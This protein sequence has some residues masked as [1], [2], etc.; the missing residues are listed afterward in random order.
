[1]GSDGKGDLGSEHM[2]LAGIRGCRLGLEKGISNPFAPE[3]CLPST[4]GIWWQGSHSWRGKSRRLGA[5]RCRNAAQAMAKPS[6]QGFLG[7]KIPPGHI[8]F[9]RGLDVGNLGH[10]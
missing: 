9:P 6:A 8:A 10:T 4:I 7:G 3:P 1:M 5:A 2:A